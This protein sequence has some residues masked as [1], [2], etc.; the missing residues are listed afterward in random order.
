MTRPALPKTDEQRLALRRDTLNRCL[1]IGE[2]LKRREQRI[3]VIS[4]GNQPAIVLDCHPSVLI[5]VQN[6]LV[7]S[8][9]IPY[10]RGSNQ[11]LCR[12]ASLA[13]RSG[14][15]ICIQTSNCQTWEM[16]DRFDAEAPPAPPNLSP[17]RATHDRFR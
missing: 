3:K 5:A 8:L 12:Y 9:S 4:I 11:G 2:K 17:R 13:S 7:H 14:F 6:V 15:R 10:R 1:A 16:G